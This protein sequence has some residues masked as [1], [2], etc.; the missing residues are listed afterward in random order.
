MNLSGFILIGALFDASRE[1]NYVLGCMRKP[2]MLLMRR[3]HGEN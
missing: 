1:T 2:E 3:F